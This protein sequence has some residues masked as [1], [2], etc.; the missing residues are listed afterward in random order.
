MTLHPDRIREL[1]A[2]FVASDALSPSQAGSIRVYLDLLLK[3]NSKIN[4][5]SVRDSEEIVV[6]HFGESLFAAC[7]LF[8]E[9]ATASVI[10]VGSGAGFPGIP[11]KIW[12]ESTNL[13]LV[14][15]NGKKATFLREVVRVLNLGQVGVESK[16]AEDLIAGANVVTL[17]AVESFGRVLLS[18]RRLLLP[19]ARLALLIGEAQIDAAQSA[20]PDLKWRDPIKIP[21]SDNRVL[22]VGY[23]EVAG[24]TIDKCSTWNI[25]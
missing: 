8:P 20:L 25:L 22:F 19:A 16:R 14:E 7:Q 24:R 9:P 18:A 17:R 21:L 3:W 10:D 11:I 4:L 23:C 15:S 6:R 12:N 1:L 13:T 5:T 2:P